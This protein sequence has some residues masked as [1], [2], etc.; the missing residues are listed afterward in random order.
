[1][2]QSIFFSWQAD[3]QTRVGRNFL[4]EVL[5]EVCAGIVADANIDEA[6]RDIVI[7]SDTQGVAGQPPIVETIFRKIDA[8]AVFIADM[9]FVG[10]RIDSRPTPNP[11]VLIEYGWA[12]KSLKHERVICVM[13]DAYGAPTRDNL[14]FDLSHVRWPIR[15]TLSENSTPDI[16][17]QEKRKLVAILSEAIRASFA[18][19]S[20]TQI[21]NPDPFPLANA[22]KDR[23]RFRGPNE[24]IGFTDDFTGDTPK[25]VFLSDGPAIWLRLMPLYDSG[26]R[27]PAH[28]LKPHMVENNQMNLI[29]LINGAGGYG[30]LRAADGV[31]MYRSNLRN[32]E[33]DDSILIDSFAFAFETGEIWSVDTTL[34][35]YSGSSLPFTE[36]IYT[37]CF[38]HYKNFLQSIG[39]QPP[40]KWIAGITGVKNRNFNYPVQQGYARISSTGPR[41]A[42]D[43]IVVEGEYDGQ[44][45]ALITLMPFFAK[46]FEQCGLP[47]PEYLPQE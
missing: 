9:T 19:I 10:T 3:T 24:P 22:K 8:S 26:K 39:I 20:I 25:D 44:Q 2:S 32:K 13:N 45:S 6:I 7:D 17:A 15:Y 27:W 35:A 5:E 14:P 36:D 37:K 46:I 28:E 29:P 33:G 41:C 30:S 1:M 18:T 16:K 43:F 47:R 38:Q 23:A 40:Y 4:R 31:G 34:L 12:L 11:N 21:K 42:N